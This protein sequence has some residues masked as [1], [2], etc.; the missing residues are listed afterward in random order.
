MLLQNALMGRK[1][2]AAVISA[3]FVGITLGST[4]TAIANRIA[5]TQQYGAAHRAVIAVP[6]VCGFFIDFVDALAISLSSP[7]EE[8]KLTSV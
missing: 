5:V 6:L 7:V 8:D 1:H 2:E 4:T 3:A